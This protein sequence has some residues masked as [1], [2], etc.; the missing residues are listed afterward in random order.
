MVEVVNNIWLDCFDGQASLRLLIDPP[1]PSRV[2]LIDPIVFESKPPNETD[3]KFVS[4][5]RGEK[6]YFTAGEI[7]KHLIKF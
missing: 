6:V 7:D 3:E 1:P 4:F 2:R 5:L